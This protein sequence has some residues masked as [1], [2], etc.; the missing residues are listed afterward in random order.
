[1][2]ANLCIWCLK[3][4]FDAD[5]EHIFPEALGCPASMTL[6][7]TV[8][9]RGCNNGLAH[10]DQIVAADFDFLTLMQ[11]IPRKGGRAPEIDSRGNVFGR[12][13]DSKP[14]IFFNLETHSVDTH[15][16]RHLSPYRGAARDV[17]PTIKR[18][19]LMSELNFEVPIGQHKKFVRGIVKIAVSA[20][21]FVA[22][23][24]IVR[25]PK[26]DWARQYVKHGGP[27]RHVLLRALPDSIYALAV[28]SP[29]KSIDGDYCLE[30]RIANIGFFV[31]L[32]PSESSYPVLHA[33]MLET[34][35]KN[36]W[37]SLP[38]GV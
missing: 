18:N 25:A 7:G 8:V 11:R 4:T 3:P 31:D 30:I 6:P 26:F 37:S 16:G 1:M 33:K 15:A 2:N 35:G 29:V 9:C 34:Y 27:T 20:L 32:S 12:L 21:A 38:I 22:S 36:G 10:L 19:G 17:R 23:A 13:A 5:V 28:E 24:D 14:E